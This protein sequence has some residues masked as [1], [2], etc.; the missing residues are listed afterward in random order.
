V[1]T[2]E[3]PIVCERTMR[4]TCNQPGAALAEF[5]VARGCALLSIIGH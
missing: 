5:P 4:Q 1:V 2:E 3:T